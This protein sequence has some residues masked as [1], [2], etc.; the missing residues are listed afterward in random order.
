MDIKKSLENYYKVECY[1]NGKL[2]WVED[3]TNLVTTV[4]L[5]DSLDK[6]LKGSNYSA[7][8]FVGLTGASPAFAAGDTAD[9]HA[10]WTEVVAYNEATRPTY[11]PSNASAGSAD[12]SASK[13]VFTVN[14]DNTQVGGAFIISQSAKGGTAGILYGEGPFSSN[15]TLAS[16]DEL[17]VT[18]T[19]TAASA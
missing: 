15:R 3:I 7:T 10:G 18:I 4:G 16:G 17:R 1:R 9:S 6:H 19:C 14:A 5:N 2:L 13:A 11:S 8:W 12:N